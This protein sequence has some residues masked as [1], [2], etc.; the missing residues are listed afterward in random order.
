MILLTLLS[1]W[2]SVTFFLFREPSKRSL[3]TALCFPPSVWYTLCPPMVSL[4]RGPRTWPTKILLG[5]ARARIFP[6]SVYTVLLFA[7]LGLLLLTAEKGGA[8]RL[9]VSEILSRS[10]QKK[11]NSG[12]EVSRCRF[13]GRHSFIFQ[14]PLLSMGVEKGEPYSNYCIN[15]AIWFW[16]LPKGSS[17]RKK[18]IFFVSSCKYLNLFLNGIF[19]TFP[20]PD[21]S[22]VFSGCLAHPS[23]LCLPQRLCVCFSNLKK[24]FTEIPPWRK[25]VWVNTLWAR[26]NALIMKSVVLR[27]E[28]ICPVIIISLSFICHKHRMAGCIRR[29]CLESAEWVSLHK[30][31]SSCSQ[32]CST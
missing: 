17:F 8:K 23:F 9:W 1:D 12:S 10:D 20:W 4:R 7:Q 31:F 3:S 2:F 14:C 25:T 32:N 16:D 27:Q 19:V 13:R 22:I 24:L 28:R 29:P 11:W 30:E 15:V 6:Q 26:A 5:R 21:W 18:L